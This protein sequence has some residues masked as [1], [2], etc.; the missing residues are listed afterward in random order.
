MLLH[1]LHAHKHR[2]TYIHSPARGPI[3]WDSTWATTTLHLNA[4]HIDKTLHDALKTM[5]VL[6]SLT[7]LSMSTRKHQTKKPAGGAC[8]EVRVVKLE[9]VNGP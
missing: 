7:V 3:Y 1:I 6:S 8:L 2:H 4:E 5:C 9:P